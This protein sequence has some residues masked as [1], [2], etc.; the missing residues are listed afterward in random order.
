MIVKYFD[1][2]F[3]LDKRKPGA[4]KSASYKNGILVD[5]RNVSVKY[6]DTL[7]LNNLNW[8]VRR[9]ENWAIVGPSGSGKSTLLSLIAGDNPQA[10]GK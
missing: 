9:H 8:T 4:A 7:V 2:G 6:G 10:Y 3:T 1:H 5:M